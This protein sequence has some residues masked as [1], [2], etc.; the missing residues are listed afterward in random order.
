VTDLP[1]I[2]NSE[3]GM[4]ADCPRRWW[5]THVL[6]LGL[7]K[8]K[9]PVTGALAFGTRIHRCLELKYEQGQDPLDAY[10]ELHKA[11]VEALDASEAALGYPDPD[12]RTKLDQ[13][14]SLGRA[15]LEGF[16]QWAADTGLDEGMTFLGAE[17]LVQ[18]A[19][20]IEGV[21]LRGK[22]DQLWKRDIDG[23]QLFR[24]FKTAA[25]LTS[26]PAMLPMNEQ[27]MFYV[28]LLRLE[29]LATGNQDMDGLPRG[30]MYTMLKKVKRTARA[31]PPFYDQVEV[32]YNDQALR[33]MY[34]R[35]HRRL[36]LMLDA[37]AR[38]G[39]GQD[40]RYVVPPRPTKDCSWKC[41][42]LHVC[43]MADDTPDETFFPM[44]DQLFVTV[45]PYER[46]LEEDAK[47]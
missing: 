22:L 42:F 11:A 37:R 10:E 30:G 40:H 38:L 19:S 31:N 27:F 18:V 21:M 24:D 2:S 26:G 6:N 14:H 16:E 12:Q 45:D 29:R 5:F 33:S 17:R 36:E 3:M 4:F 8:V 23:A 43:P 1:A 41:P 25:E 47:A 34:L 28:L 9:V 46:Y 13:E 15:M 44:L 32:M 35:V 20:G 7:P 39:A